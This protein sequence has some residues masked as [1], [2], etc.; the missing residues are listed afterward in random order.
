MSEFKYKCVEQINSMPGK[1]LVG[2]FA[3]ILVLLG[4]LSL[5]VSLTAKPASAGYIGWQPEWVKRIDNVTFSSMN[6]LELITDSL[7]P[8][9]DDRVLIKIVTSTSTLYLVNITNG[10]VLFN[11]KVEGV[12]IPP[13]GERVFAIFGSGDTRYVAVI[14]GKSQV[15]IRDII[16]KQ[17][18]TFT[19][20]YTDNPV[21]VSIVISPTGRYVIIGDRNGYLAVYKGKLIGNTVEGFDFQFLKIVGGQSGIRTIQDARSIDANSPAGYVGITIGVDSGRGFFLSKEGKTVWDT[22]VSTNKITSSD[23][24]HDGKFAVYAGDGGTVKF[25]NTRAPPHLWSA[26]AGADVLSIAVSG[27]GDSVVLGTEKSGSYGNIRFYAGAKA[28]TGTTTPTWSK[29]TGDDVIAISISKNGSRI[30]AGSEDDKVY[31]F[32][33]A[34]NAIKPA[35]SM[36]NDVVDVAIS[37]DGRYAI[38]ASKSKASMFDLSNNV[39]TPIWTHQ[40]V[41]GDRGDIGEPRAVAIAYD[42]GYVAVAGGKPALVVLKGTTGEILMTSLAGVTPSGSRDVAM[43]WD[44][45]YIVLTGSGGRVQFWDRTQSSPIWENQLI[46]GDARK[47][48]MS[49]DG[50]IIVVGSTDKV[51]YGWTGANKLRGEDQG[52]SWIFKAADLDEDQDEDDD[53]NAGVNTVAISKEVQYQIDVQFSREESMVISGGN[54]VVKSATLPSIFVGEL[55]TVQDSK[56]RIYRLD[57]GQSSHTIKTNERVTLRFAIPA[58]SEDEAPGG[59]YT[60]TMALRF[61]DEFARPFNR[62]FKLANIDT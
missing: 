10:D 55:V 13:G 5:A 39:A 48:A 44:G 2:V 57:L 41:R 36:G 59:T 53:N 30:V 37:Q 49:Y 32:D 58:N 60:P 3:L 34:G 46:R 31:F 26:S 8:L 51:V 33:A 24:S 38:A 45:R 25:Y 22:S 56:G 14:T 12:A 19:L 52:P 15:V 7:D 9:S 20:A 28:R 11:R 43:S 17:S 61:I 4:M 23:I 18:V 16:N 42:G 21:P 54:F 1:P 35:Y 6:N 50:S 40:K 27:D 62:Q 47:V 29:Q